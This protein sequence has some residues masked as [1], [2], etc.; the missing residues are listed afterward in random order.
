MH[1]AHNKFIGK[2]S[3]NPENVHP[4]INHAV[5]N[6]YTECVDPKRD[7]WTTKKWPTLKKTPLRV[8]DHSKSPSQTRATRSTYVIFIA[9]TI[10]S[11][12]SRITRFAKA[13]YVSLL[14]ADQPGF[15]DR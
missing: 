8:P 12:R 3:N 7:Q 4:G 9:L 2:E 11:P 10:L 13:F 1:V 14:P 15:C 5:E 6:A